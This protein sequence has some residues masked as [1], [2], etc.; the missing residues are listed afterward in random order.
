[1]PANP[2]QYQSSDANGVLGSENAHATYAMVPAAISH[3]GHFQGAH[4]MRLPAVFTLVMYTTQMTSGVANKKHQKT[5]QQELASG[6][7]VH[8]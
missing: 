6:N 5:D 1:M 8:S 3:R 2:V 4:G 7:F